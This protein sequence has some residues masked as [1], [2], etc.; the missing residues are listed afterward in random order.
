[1]APPLPRGVSPGEVRDLFLEMNRLALAAPSPGE[2]RP[3][4]PAFERLGQ[5]AVPTFVL[6]GS[7]DLPFIVERSSL[8]ADL[9]PT[10]RV[11]PVGQG[12]RTSPP[13]SNQTWSSRSSRVSCPVTDH[14]PARTRAPT[15]VPPPMTSVEEDVRL[16]FCVGTVG[17][18]GEVGD[19]FL[20]QHLVVDVEVARRLAARSAEDGVGGVGHDLRL[21]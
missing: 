10:A 20:G 12:W 21:P 2:E 13:W 19:A 3:R 5:I 14:P 8:V 11:R 18:P 7:L 16:E 15:P 4:P 1:M 17:V 6:V 9:I